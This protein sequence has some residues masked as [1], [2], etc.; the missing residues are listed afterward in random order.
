MYWLYNFV[1]KRLEIRRKNLSL[2]IYI[3]IPEKFFDSSFYISFL[4]QLFTDVYISNFS[5][6]RHRSCCLFFTLSF[7]LALFRSF[8]SMKV[9]DLFIW[10]NY[11]NDRRKEKESNNSSWRQESSQVSTQEFCAYLLCC[12]PKQLE[13]FQEHGNSWKIKRWRKHYK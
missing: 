12:Y 3:F 1:F 6:R 13:K 10:S 9:V 2:S 4:F 8:Y 5:I 11:D 7:S